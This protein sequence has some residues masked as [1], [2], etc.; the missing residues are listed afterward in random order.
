[1]AFM[2]SILARRAKEHATTEQASEGPSVDDLTRS[3]VDS[4]PTILCDARRVIEIGE[5]DVARQAVKNV[6]RKPEAQKETLLK[7]EELEELRSRV[8]DATRAYTD[9]IAQLDRIAEIKA[10]G[11]VRQTERRVKNHVVGLLKRHCEHCAGEAALCS[12]KEDCTRRDGLACVE[13][14]CRHCAGFRDTCSCKVGCARKECA[15]CLPRHCAHCK[16]RP[17]RCGCTFGCPRGEGIACA[18]H[19]IIEPE[20]YKGRHKKED[21]GQ[22]KEVKQPAG[23]PE[24]KIEPPGEDDEAEGDDEA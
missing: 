11:R 15:R 6:V 4:V 22:H 2:Q 19:T 7:K 13:R 12:C 20:G 23:P 1:M 3:V 17:A 16:G 14:H 8:R 18:P 24:E 21:E 9:L 10:A 5:N